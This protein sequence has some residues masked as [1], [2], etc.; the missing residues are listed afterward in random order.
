MK[1]F[2]FKYPWPSQFFMTWMNPATTNNVNKMAYSTVSWQWNTAEHFVCMW[3]WDCWAVDQEA[4]RL[5]RCRATCPLCVAESQRLFQLQ[6]SLLNLNKHAHAVFMTKVNFVSLCAKTQHAQ[7]KWHTELQPLL[8]FPT[9]PVPSSL[10]IHQHTLTHSQK[11]RTH[12][13]TL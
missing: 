6:S 13:H 10:C 12:I 8:C 11:R 9:V 5:A 3:V 4:K 7:A 1:I 2:C